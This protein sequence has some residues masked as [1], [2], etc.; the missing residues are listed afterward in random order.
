MKSRTWLR[1]VVWSPGQGSCGPASVG[2]KVSRRRASIERH[3]HIWH[4]FNH[5]Y[6]TVRFTKFKFMREVLISVVFR[7]NLNLCH[8]HHLRRV[9]FLQWVRKIWGTWSPLLISIAVPTFDAS[10]FVTTYFPIP[11]FA[12]LFFGYKF[13]NKSKMVDY[14]NM[15]FVTGS[16]IEVTEKV[17]PVLSQVFHLINSWLSRRALRICGRRF[18][19]G[20]R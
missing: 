17:S 11:F 5:I 18:P 13:W 15:D 9:W 14:A 2:T 20:S 7:W 12:V 4:L 16:S 1:C 3:S 6:R 10:T 8:G 19:I